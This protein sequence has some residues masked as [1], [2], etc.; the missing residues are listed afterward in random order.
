MLY[1]RTVNAAHHLDIQLERIFKALEESGALDNTILILTGDHGEE[2]YE[3]GR[4]GHN[5]AFTKEQLHVPMVLIAPGIKPNVYEGFSHHT[6]IVPTLAPFLGV[7]NAAVDYS[8]GGNL[9]DS[10]HRRDFF[11][12]CGW[13]MAAIVTCTRKY[14]VSLGSRRLISRQTLTTFDDEPVNGEDFVKENIEFVTKAQRDMTR[15]VV[16]GNK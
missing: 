14:V 11:V 8:V 7:E 10:A 15:F 4:L 5:S 13:D 16:K 2:F 6:D 12:S 9:L 1:N 3:K